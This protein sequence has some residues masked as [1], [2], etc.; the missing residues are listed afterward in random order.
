MSG[1]T[2]VVVVG[3]GTVVVACFAVV[4]G[5]TSTWVG[6]VVERSLG[7]V[8]ERLLDADLLEL[9]APSSSGVATS[10]AT[11]APRADPIRRCRMA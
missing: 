7:D 5:L 4:D 3:G 11:A 8:V 10:R 2:V 6:D 9:H 1:A